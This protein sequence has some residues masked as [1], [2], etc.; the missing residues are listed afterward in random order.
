MLVSQPTL[1]IGLGGIWIVENFF[2]KYC[3]MVSLDVY[4]DIIII[5][6]LKFL[7]SFIINMMT[8]CV[9]GTCSLIVLYIKCLGGMFL[10]ENF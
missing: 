1:A 7:I 9:E 3:N 2:R 6:P 10:R 8:L 5:I 4:S